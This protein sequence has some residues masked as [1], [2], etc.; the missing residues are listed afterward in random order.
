[1]LSR[2]QYLVDAYRLLARTGV[3]NDSRRRHALD[4]YGHRPGGGYPT[5]SEAAVSRSPARTCLPLM[6][7]RIWAGLA[8][9]GHGRL[10]NSP[11]VRHVPPALIAPIAG[12][13]PT[14]RLLYS[15]MTRGTAVYKCAW[16]CWPGRSPR[17]GSGSQSGLIPQS[18]PPGDNHPTRLPQ[19]RRIGKRPLV[20]RQVNSPVKVSVRACGHHV[21]TGC[22]RRCRGYRGAS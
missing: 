13:C 19:I 2:A 15:Y 6:R 20:V 3:H 4:M 22:L 17:E 21:D 12:E 10:M 7:A 8:A 9:S 14:L 5:S 11:L 18:L 16:S 1:M